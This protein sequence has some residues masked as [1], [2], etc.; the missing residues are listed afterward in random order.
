[1][2][3]LHLVEFANVSKCKL[4]FLSVSFSGC[5]KWGSQVED[6]VYNMNTVLC[7]VT[8]EAKLF[9]V[10]SVTDKRWIPESIMYR[11]FSV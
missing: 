1:M 9:P 6:D 7:L 5:G 10:T 4:C 3:L 8:P 2:S 11:N